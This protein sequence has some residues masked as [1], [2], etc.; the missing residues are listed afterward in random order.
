MSSCIGRC[1]WVSTHPDPT[2][3]YVETSFAKMFTNWHNSSCSRS[4]LQFHWPSC[5]KSATVFLLNLLLCVENWES[6]RYKAN[7]TTRRSSC[8]TW[9]SIG[10]AFQ[11]AVCFVT[12][13]SRL[14]TPQC[15][16]SCTL[17]GSLIVL[18]LQEHT[19]KMFL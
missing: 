2:V 1:C 18:F 12:Y 4:L 9:G 17:D 16:I 7:C 19:P 15:P 5:Q 3:E 11:H 8:K 10:C 14:T 6:G 13:I